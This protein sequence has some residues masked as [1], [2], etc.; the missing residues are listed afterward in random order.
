LHPSGVAYS[1]TS[2]GWG[3]GGS[4]TS[5]RWQVT[6]CDPMW[7]V[8]SHS[9]VATLQT[10]IHLLLTYLDR[11]MSTLP[12]LSCGVWPIYLYLTEA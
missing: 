6:L 4:V 9:G 5:V 8:S 10:A 7:H 12:M 1:S 2:L 11:E 3:K